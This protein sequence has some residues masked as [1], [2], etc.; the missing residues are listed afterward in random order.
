[1]GVHFRG[2][3]NARTNVVYDPR[4]ER[5]HDFPK[6]THRVE[7]IDTDRLPDLPPPQAFA[8]EQK[9]VGGLGPHIRMTFLADLATPKTDVPMRVMGVRGEERE[10]VVSILTSS[11]LAP[12]VGNVGAFEDEAT[13]GGEEGE[14]GGEDGAE[15]WNG[16]EGS[17]SPACA[18]PAAESTYFLL[19]TVHVSENV[20]LVASVLHEGGLCCLPNDEEDVRTTSIFADRFDRF[21]PNNWPF[22]AEE[23]AAL[24]AP[25]RESERWPMSF[26]PRDVQPAFS[27]EGV[28]RAL[29]GAAREVPFAARHIPQPLRTFFRNEAKA[30]REEGERKAR[31]RDA[32]ALAALTALLSAAE[33]DRPC[34]SAPPAL[35]AELRAEVLRLRLATGEGAAGAPSGSRD[36]VQALLSHDPTPMLSRKLTQEQQRQA[37][38]AFYYLQINPQKK[39][40][41]ES[42]GILF[43]YYLSGYLVR[44]VGKYTYTGD[45]RGRGRALRTFQNSEHNVISEERRM[46]LQQPDGSIQCQN[47]V[48]G[49]RGRHRA[50]LK[51]ED[52][53]VPRGKRLKPKAVLR[54]QRFNPLDR[55]GWEREEGEGGEEAEGR[56]E[57]AD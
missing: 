36:V 56:V 38:C 33:T 49:Y 39:Y 23:N 21:G 46:L 42:K 37:L 6:E 41:A 50:G 30:V 17:A 10:K 4:E 13:V 20:V 3:C 52:V 1:M 24:V 14:E 27:Y 51:Q 19:F 25:R 35:L 26:L 22:D 32:A 29:V 43:L 54:E 15:S 5:F 40:E 9:T 7:V 44:F 18:A 57:K 31:E 45:K 12:L 28:A 2:L 47:T 55:D 34:S 8:E 16:G 48:D 53:Y 11:L